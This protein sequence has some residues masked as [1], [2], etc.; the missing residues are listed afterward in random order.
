[1]ENYNNNANNI[2]KNNLQ[3]LQQN[4]V[5]VDLSN[6]NERRNFYNS[7]NARSTELKKP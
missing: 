3:Y 6:M 5:N 7:L 1:M 4:N 2:M